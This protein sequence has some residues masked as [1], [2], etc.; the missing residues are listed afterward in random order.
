MFVI[1]NVFLKRNLSYPKAIEAKQKS[2][3]SESGLPASRYELLAMLQE[4]GLI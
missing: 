2:Y 3:S 4:S 1:P